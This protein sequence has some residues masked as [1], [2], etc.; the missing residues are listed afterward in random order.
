MKI[1][2]N[3]IFLSCIIAILFASC[4]KE[5]NIDLPYEGD[6]IVLNSFM[7]KDSLIYVRLTNST[8]LANTSSFP[9]PAGARVDLYE[10][11]VI[12]ETLVRRFI[13]GKE[14]FVSASKAAGGK[15]YTMKASATGL[16]N[17]EGTDTIPTKPSFVPVEFKETPGS[18]N[19]QA[20]LV[21]NLNDPPGEKNY[22]RLRLYSVDTNLSSVGP[23]LLV[24]KDNFIYFKVDNIASNYDFDIFGGDIDYWQIYFPDDKFDGRNVSLTINI[25]N[26]FTN[27]QYLA[28]ELVHLTRDSYRYLQSSGNQ[29][30]NEGNPFT[31]AVVVYNNIKGGYGIVGGMADSI[32]IIRKQ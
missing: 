3:Y 29:F 30:D 10:N 11:D 6:K 27:V 2:I 13:F 17:A 32:A 4:E 25:S 24:D 18:S 12:K 9:I 7:M 20:R 31:E 8:Q 19:H 15:K 1:K 21:I 5:V 23:R 22:Y 28:P 14:Y 16:D 26:F